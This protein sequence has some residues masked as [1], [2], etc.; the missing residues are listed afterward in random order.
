M[1]LKLGGY[2]FSGP[3][4]LGKAK[5]R[6][7]QKAVVFGIICREGKAW[8]PVFRVIDIDQSGSEGIVFAEDERM[9]EWSE[10]GGENI[11]VYYLEDDNGVTETVEGRSSLVNDLRSSFPPPNATVSVDGMM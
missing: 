2:L 1:G 3:F 7:H 5:V 8:D 11:S 9:S 10:K 4:D 6:K